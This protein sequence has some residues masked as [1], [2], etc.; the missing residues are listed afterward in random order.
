MRNTPSGSVLLQLHLRQICVCLP[1]TAI[2]DARQTKPL[3]R[4]AGPRTM[5]LV[6]NGA[7]AIPSTGSSA[8]L[9]MTLLLLALSSPP[10]LAS[11]FRGGFIT[12]TTNSPNTPAE[13]ATVTFT[14]TMFYRQVVM[15][16]QPP[17]C[18]AV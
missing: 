17:S 15:A 9:V 4:F 14:F 12:Y 18:K 1:L 10:A 8:R 11:H 13:E 16:L 2:A 7:S 3:G 5:I 6:V